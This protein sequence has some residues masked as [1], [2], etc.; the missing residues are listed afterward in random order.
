MPQRAAED[1]GRVRAAVESSGRHARS[2]V[3]KCGGRQ[4]EG[5]SRAAARGV[6]RGAAIM[7][8]CL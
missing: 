2:R 7:K 6:V 5:G 1:G 3:R 8:P 4:V